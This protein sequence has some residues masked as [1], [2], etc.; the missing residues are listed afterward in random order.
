MPRKNSLFSGQNLFKSTLVSI[1]VLAPSLV[2]WLFLMANHVPATHAYLV[3]CGVLLLAVIDFAV[4][5]LLEPYRR[6]LGLLTMLSF[7]GVIGI[8]LLFVAAD[9]LNRF[10]DHLGYGI[11]TPVAIGG[12]LLLTAAIFCEKNTVLKCHLSINSIAL[13]VLWAMGAADKVTMPF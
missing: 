7:I 12:A 3:A 5:V 8:V 9:A 13:A 10:I 6:R 2:S 1:F 4:I 11:V